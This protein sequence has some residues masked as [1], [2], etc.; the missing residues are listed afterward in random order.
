VEGIDAPALTSW[1]NE[2]ASKFGRQNVADLCLAYVRGQDWI[3]GVVIGMET[4]AQLEANLLLS[5]RAPL[6]LTDCA[7][8]E[9]CRPRVPERLLDPARW[10]SR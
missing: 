10:P 2:C 4:E 9:S 6:A 3:D 1:L 5:T 7:V 8:I